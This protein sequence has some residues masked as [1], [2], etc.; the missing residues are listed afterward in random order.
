MT[1]G[2]RS[3]NQRYISESVLHHSVD[4]LTWCNLLHTSIALL[5]TCPDL[6]SN[7]AESR[8]KMKNEEDEG[9]FR[10][11]DF[12]GFQHSQFSAQIEI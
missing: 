2:N 6:C 10:F 8:G 3:A 7:G 5:H 4:E 9:K 1:F 11:Q 12:S